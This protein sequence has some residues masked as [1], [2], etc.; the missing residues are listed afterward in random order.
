MLDAYRFGDEQDLAPFIAV[1]DVHVEIWQM[2]DRQRRRC[3]EPRSQAKP[4]R[5]QDRPTSP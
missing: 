4:L 2:Y 3:H 5:S 1:Q